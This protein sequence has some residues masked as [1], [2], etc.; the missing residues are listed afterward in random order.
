MKSPTDEVA[1]QGI[2]FWS[3]VCEEEIALTVEYE[4]V[5]LFE[6]L[7][8]WVTIM[9]SCRYFTLRAGGRNTEVVG[10][11]YFLRFGK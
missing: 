3:N 8:I 6:H 4:E 5:A 9:P 1:L 2:E 11:D 7:Y 10:I